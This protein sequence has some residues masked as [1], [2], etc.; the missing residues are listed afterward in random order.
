MKTVTINEP[1]ADELDL[2]RLSIYDEN[3]EVEAR[4]AAWM[5]NAGFPGAFDMQS[6][7]EDNMD[8][9]TRSLELAIEAAEEGNI[10]ALEPGVF[11]SAW[12]GDGGYLVQMHSNGT[13][14]LDGV[15]DAGGKI[16]TVWQARVNALIAGSEED[17]H[18]GEV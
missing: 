15:P 16:P 2:I 5:R 8:R 13:F 12:A 7:G 1:Q 14:D 17:E 10:V 9:N 3:P 11:V 6:L 18:Q 4:L